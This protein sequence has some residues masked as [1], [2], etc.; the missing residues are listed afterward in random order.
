MRGKTKHVP[1][2]LQEVLDNLDIQPG[3]TLLDG[4]IGGGGHTTRILEQFPSVR[5]IALDQ[6]SGAITKLQ[7]TISKQFPSPKLELVNANFRNLDKVLEKLSISSVDAVLLDLGLS[8]DQIDPSTS[9]GQASSGQTG[10]GFSFQRD[11]PLRMTMS[12]DSGQINAEQILNNFS[13]DAL[14][15]ILRGFGE[16][17]FSKRI[18]HEIVERREKKPFATTFDL[19]DAVLAVV[20]P[21]YKRGR[22][23]PATRT[24]Q[25]IRI[26]V[27]EELVALEEG[28][29][30]GFKSLNPMGRMVVISFHSLE[31]R[32]V[33]NFFRELARGG[34]AE[35]IT[36]HPITPKES[37]VRANPR[38]RS[39]KMRVMRK[40]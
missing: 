18:A 34:L 36:K 25:A 30:K 3:D 16:E 2:L 6:D 1:V 15:V 26:A 4:T 38:A 8:S 33:K 21:V 17:K 10:R 9:S 32:I 13:E 29:E 35:L 24:F 12:L 11:E 14:E 7:E 22:I 20:P 28:L 23:N 39:A 27:N 19:R 5:V 37:E 31:D 40:L